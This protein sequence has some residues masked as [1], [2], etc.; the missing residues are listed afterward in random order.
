MILK[1]LKNNG[2]QANAPSKLLARIIKVK[3]TGWLLG[4][5]KCQQHSAKLG[6]GS[7]Q[8]NLQVSSYPATQSSYQT[9]QSTI[10]L[11]AGETVENFNAFCTYILCI[12]TPVFQPTAGT[13][14]NTPTLETKP[15]TTPNEAHG[16]R[17]HHLL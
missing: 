6:H 12:A 1:A 5:T 16:L 3:R 14:N 4:E 11:L 13:D 2:D 9:S 8:F 17:L 10:H 7:P 15:T